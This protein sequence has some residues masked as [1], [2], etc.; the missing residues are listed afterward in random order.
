[1]KLGI[2]MLNHN[3]EDIEFVTEFPCFLGQPVKQVFS[4]NTF[5]EIELIKNTLYFSIYASQVLKMNNLQK[6]KTIT[7]FKMNKITKLN[8]NY[9]SIVK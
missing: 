6:K 2:T 4:N 9:F 5:V 3:K 8:N 7:W 1:M